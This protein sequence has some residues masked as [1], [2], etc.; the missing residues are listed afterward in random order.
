MFSIVTCCWNSEPFIRQSIESVLMQD[1]PHIEY[2]FVDGGSTDGTLE[3]IRAIP[4]PV[5][6]FTDVGGGISRAMNHGIE[7]ATGDV[8]A[9]LH[10]DDYYAAPDAIRTVARAFESTGARWIFG[11]NLRDKQGRPEPETWE[12]PHYSYRRL[13]K[14]NFIPHESTFVRRE[15]LLEA[16]PFSAHWKYGMDYDMWLR[17]GRMAEPVQ[18]D[19]DIGVFREHDKSLSSS[20]AMAGF[21]EDLQIRLAHVGPSPLARLYHYAHYQVRRR[22]RRRAM[23]AS[24]GSA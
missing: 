12:P 10:A 11:K 5:R 16:G 24:E 20:N 6:L 22:R 9:H 19:L 13:M 21:E 18:L 1:Y 17:L 2:I 8:V 23:L 15:L 14:G 3:R 7:V 4:R